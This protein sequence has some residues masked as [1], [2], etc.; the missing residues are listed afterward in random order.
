MIYLHGSPWPMEGQAMSHLWSL[1]PKNI[2]P[3][4]KSQFQV[5]GVQSLYAAL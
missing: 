1:Q 5:V 4:D 2:K 3:K